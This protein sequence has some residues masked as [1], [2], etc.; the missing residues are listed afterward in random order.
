MINICL[1]S[2]PVYLPELL[3]RQYSFLIM[4]FPPAETAFLVIRAD[5]MF[6]PFTYSTFLAI[7]SG[8]GKG[9]QEAVSNI[10]KNFTLLEVT[11]RD[12]I[13]IVF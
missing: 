5:L 10:L 1:D 7:Q 12:Y 8:S 4:L 9:H 11:I 6:L 13:H 3:G 2:S